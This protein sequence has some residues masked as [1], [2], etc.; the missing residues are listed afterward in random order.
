MDKTVFGDNKGE[1]HRRDFVSSEDEW[2]GGNRR[3]SLKDI[4]NAP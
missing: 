4:R 1:I 2:G 3:A